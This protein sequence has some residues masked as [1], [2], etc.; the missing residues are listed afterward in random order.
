[1]SRVVF[2][3][4]D[5]GFELSQPLAERAAGIGKSLGPQDQQ[6]H[7]QNQNDVGGLKD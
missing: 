6:G 3:A 4:A 5:R 7:D 1:M 2:V